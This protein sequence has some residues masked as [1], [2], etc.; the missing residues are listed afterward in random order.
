MN[1]G[2]RHGKARKRVKSAGQDAQMVKRDAAGIG[3]D[4]CA[5]RTFATS[6]GYAAPR[7]I[8][9]HASLLELDNNGVCTAARAGPS[10]A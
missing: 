3:P 5:G 2:K 10:T 7:L 9:C 4:A 1:I 8:G 6:V